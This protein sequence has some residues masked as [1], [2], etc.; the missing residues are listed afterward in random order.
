MLKRLTNKQ[1]EILDKV[2]IKPCTMPELAKHFGITKQAIHERVLLMRKKG[3]LE[4]TGPIKPTTEGIHAI[5]ERLC[6]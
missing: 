5:I 4:P 3:Y 6:L 2:M 1:R